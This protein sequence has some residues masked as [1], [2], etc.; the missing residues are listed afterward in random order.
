MFSLKL[1]FKKTPSIFSFLTI[2]FKYIAKSI[3]D[4]VINQAIGKYSFRFW[5][6]KRSILS[7]NNNCNNSNNDNFP[8]ARCI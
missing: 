1:R 2:S 5:H 7:N 4:S 6:T 8:V 3:P